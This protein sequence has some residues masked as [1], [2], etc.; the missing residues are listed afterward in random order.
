MKI[1]RMRITC[2]IPKATNTHSQ[3]VTHIAY[4]RQQWLHECVSILRCTYTACPVLYLVRASHTFHIRFVITEHIT[5]KC[6][7]GKVIKTHLTGSVCFFLAASLGH[8]IL[9][10]LSRPKLCS[11]VKISE[12]CRFIHSSRTP[13]SS[14]FPGHEVNDLILVVL[15]FCHARYWFYAPISR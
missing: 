12:K 5:T 1:W 9:P 4:P 14:R 7:L 2:W 13:L 6:D 8:N 15:W 11:W 10:T 3:Y